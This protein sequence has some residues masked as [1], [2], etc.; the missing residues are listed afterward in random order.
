MFIV[1]LRSISL[2]FTALFVTLPF[3]TIIASSARADADPFLISTTLQ[4]YAAQKDLYSEGEGEPDGESIFL[5]WEQYAA[6]GGII[7]LALGIVW[8]AE[9]QPSPCMVATAAY[10]TPLSPGLSV[11]RTFR[12]RTLLD[13]AWGTAFVDVYYRVGTDIAG[14]VSDHRWA[15]WLVRLVLA[16]LIL[17]AALVLCCPGILSATGYI[18]LVTAVLIVL[19]WLRRTWG[20]DAPDVQANMYR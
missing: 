3:I 9:D 15:A 7:S 1:I 16:P 17:V 14:F 20:F 11:L 12:D 6:L 10:G 8:L 5:P 13:S 19:Y 2:F 4:Q 18:L